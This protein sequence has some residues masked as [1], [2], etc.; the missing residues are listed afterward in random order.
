MLAKTPVFNEIFCHF[1]QVSSLLLYN[2]VLQ[3]PETSE[4]SIFR[5]VYGMALRIEMLMMVR[6]FPVQPESYLP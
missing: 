5:K 6:Q 1:L 4:F 2:I 3:Q